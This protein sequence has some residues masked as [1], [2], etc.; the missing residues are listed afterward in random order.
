ML[1]TFAM[2]KPDATQRNLETEIAN[3]IRNSGWAIIKSVPCTLLRAQAAWLYREHEGKDF[4]PGLVDYTTSGPVVLLLL[5]WDDRIPRS[6]ADAPSLF[7]QHMGATDH[8]QAAEGTIRK[9]FAIGYR[10]NSIHG[11]DGADAAIREISYFFGTEHVANS[12]V[13]P[14]TALV[15]SYVD[16]ANYKRT[17]T[18]T[19]SGGFTEEQKVLFLETLDEEGFFVPTAV[20]LPCLFDTPWTPDDHSFHRID[21]IYL[22]ASS[23]DDSRTIDQLIPIFQ[24]I[25][26]AEA[27]GETAFKYAL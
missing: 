3:F 15:L 5:E 16:G 9:A 27:A 13:K 1:R 18:W 4:F 24:N 22:T 21:D 20:D 10:E 25:D 26:W 14:N 6:V 12:I 17:K 23:P 8:T 7:R 11:S 19:V 2:I